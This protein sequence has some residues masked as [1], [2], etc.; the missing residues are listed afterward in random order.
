MANKKINIRDLSTEEL[1][2]RIEEDKARLRKLRFNHTVAALE[3]PNVLR[4]LRRDIAR[5]NT[6]LRRRELE[7]SSANK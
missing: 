2:D 3:N 6:E 4:N 7:D 1:F 5:Y